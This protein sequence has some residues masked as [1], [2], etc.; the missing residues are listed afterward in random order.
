MTHFEILKSKM[1]VAFFPMYVRPS[2]IGGSIVLWLYVIQ[3]LSGVLLGL[4]Y[5][6]VFDT[7]LPGVIFFWWETFYGSFLGRI[8]AEFGNLVFFW[9]YVHIL[10]K[11]WSSAYQAEADHTWIS[12][13]VIMI[14]TYVAGVT[15]AIMP[16]SILAEVTA[17]VIGYAINSLSFVKFDFLETLLIPGLGLTD[18]SMSR[19]FIVHG[20]FPILGL[21]VAADHI[22]NLHCTEYT[23]EDEMETIFLIRFEYWDSFVWLEVGFWYET[24]MAF[25]FFRFTADFFWPDYMT[26][27]YA[28]SNFE[29]WPITEDI[30]FALAIPHWYLRPLMGSLVVIPHHYLGFFYIITCFL[31][32]FILPWLEDTGSLSQPSVVS[33]YLQVQFPTEMNIITSYMYSMFVLLLVFTTLIVPTGKYFIALGSSEVLVFTLWFIITYLLLFLRLGSYLSQIFLSSTSW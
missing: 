32:I 4:V 5:S 7:G 10:I 8:H 16:C 1:L 29:Y 12:G 21:L 30:D 15:G 17:T 26:I 9:L 13:I 33:D 11:I 19:V 3:V 28:Q 31:L 22:A 14:F 2:L 24:L 23:D 18:D 6:W 27:S 25:L 20:L